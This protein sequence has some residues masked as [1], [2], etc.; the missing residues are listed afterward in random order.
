MGGKTGTTNEAKD[1]W[2]TGFTRRLV[3][4]SWIGF[5]DPSQSLGKSVYNRNLDKNQITGGEFGAKSAQPAWISYM[6]VAL[7]DLPN[8]PFEPPTDIVSVRIDKATG[9]LSYKTDKT[10]EFEYFQVGTQ[11]T[12]YADSDKT[13]DIFQEAG[14]IKKVEEELF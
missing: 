6:K 13:E 1:A 7:T 4:T 5:D 8:E 11:P 2:F 10:S 14:K 12:E 3:T 9:K